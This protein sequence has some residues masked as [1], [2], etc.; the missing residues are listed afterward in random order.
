MVARV[1][2]QE[3]ERLGAAGSDKVPEEPSDRFGI[4]ATSSFPHTKNATNENWNATN[5]KRRGVGAAGAAPLRGSKT[6]NKS[7]ERVGRCPFVAFVLRGKL[8][9][10]RSAK[11]FLDS[12][13]PLSEPVIPQLPGSCSRTPATIK[14]NRK[15]TAEQRRKIRH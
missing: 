15:K 1:G 9:V 13:G 12:L 14:K 6:A 8:L 4:C 3:P 10:A 5:E 2:A 11:R 7:R